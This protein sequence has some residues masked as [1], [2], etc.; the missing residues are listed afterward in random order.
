MIFRIKSVLMFAATVLFISLAAACDNSTSGPDTPDDEPDTPDDPTEVSFQLLDDNVA[1]PIE[2]GEF[3]LSYIFENRPEDGDFVINLPENHWISFVSDDSDAGI[4]TFSAGENSDPDRTDTLLIRYDYN[5]GYV[6]DTAVVSQRGRNADHYIEAAICT[7]DYYASAAGSG[8]GFGD[9]YDAWISTQGLWV[10]GSEGLDLV[11][12]AEAP[13]ETIPRPGYDGYY[14]VNIL[15]EG[16]YTYDADSH[17]P[18]TFCEY[19]FYGISSGYYYT[20]RYDIVDGWFTIEHLGDNVMY[21]EAEVTGTDGLVY[22]LTF[23]G[24]ASEFLYHN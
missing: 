18:G 4:L 14:L 10:E 7:G 3:E 1:L 21:I 8:M 16:R 24:E 12:F 17:E 6:I 13:V 23:T 5:E 11:F 19:S 2:G 9:F 15:P 20:P 22:N